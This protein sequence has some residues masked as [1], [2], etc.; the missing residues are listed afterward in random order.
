QIEGSSKDGGK[1][2]SV[3]DKFQYHRGKVSDHSNMTTT[4][5][6]YKRYKEDVKVLKGLGVDVYRFSIPW[7]RILPQGTLSGGVNKEGIDHYNS[8]IDELVKEDITPFVTLLHFD[9]PQTLQD[10]YGG[11]LDRKIVDDFKDYCELCFKTFGD[12]VKHWITINEPLVIA[13]F[14]HD[15]GFGPPGR[16]SNRTICPAGNSS[17]EPYIVTH[18]LLLAHGAVARLYKKK[19][20]AQQGGEIG[21]SLVGQ[22]HVAYNPT[23]WKDKTASSR[24][25]DFELGMQ[26]KL[27]N[28]DLLDVNLVLIR[29]MEPLVYGSYPFTMRKLVKDRLPKF[30]EEEKKMVQGSADFIGINYY[31]TRYVKNIPIDLHASPVGFSQDEFAKV[32]AFK[33]GVPIGPPADGSMFIYI[34]PQGLEDLLIFMKNKYRSPKIY[35]SENGVTEQ[36]ND[37]IAINQAVKDQHRIDYVRKHLCRIHKAIARGVNVKGYFYWS[38]FDDFEWVEGYHVRFGLY[39]IDYKSN[40]TRIP[41]ESAKWYHAFI[42]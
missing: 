30:T 17:T 16:C 38:L 21:I 27:R 14:G 19:F 33:D 40:L 7:T 5:D 13:K 11:F 22:Y 12:R 10:K 39:Y 9:L 18:N 37:K 34:Y 28:F 23:S 41:K 2:T 26:T 20:Q 29:Y 32:L 36:R 4:I 15:L 35:I 25:M 8:L 3:W 31:T 6:S 24:V 1:G 42:R